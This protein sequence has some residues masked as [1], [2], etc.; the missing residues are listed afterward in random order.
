MPNHNQRPAHQADSNRDEAAGFVEK[1]RTNPSKAVA[2]IMSAHRAHLLGPEPLTE[3]TRALLRTLRAETRDQEATNAPAVPV[4]ARQS[5]PG[6]VRMTRNTTS[7]AAATALNAGPNRHELAA[8]LLGE[9]F[10]HDLLASGISDGERVCLEDLA[11]TVGFVLDN[12]LGEPESRRDLT[13]RSPMFAEAAARYLTTWA[14]PLNLKFIRTGHLARAYADA[15]DDTGLDPA[16]TLGDAACLPAFPTMSSARDGFSFLRRSRV[17]W[18]HPHGVRHGLLLDRLHCAYRAGVIERDTWTRRKVT[19]DMQAAAAYL[20]TIRGAGE[21]L[22]ETM[23]GVRVMSHLAPNA[24]VHFL[25][26]LTALPQHED[27]QANRPAAHEDAEH[28]RDRP[29]ASSILRIDG[30]RYMVGIGDF[31][32]IGGCGHCLTTTRLPRT[33]SDTPSQASEAVTAI[34]KAAQ[35]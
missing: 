2:D 23:L 21:G 26:A 18:A 25:P 8:V 34:T 1:L 5:L 27:L 20:A 19:E 7:K 28:P 10:A 35:A 31:H 6:S 24:G 11:V 9:R 12:I 17:A 4:P 15:L 22:I 32:R 16:G 13:R 3:H 14:Q 29:A 33:D 30:R